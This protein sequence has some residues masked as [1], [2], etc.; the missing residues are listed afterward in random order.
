MQ[1][2]LKRMENISIQNSQQEDQY[3]EE[4][5][6]LSEKL[7]DVSN[8]KINFIMIVARGNGFQALCAL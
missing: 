5:R 4:I 1:E 2:K 7:K 8:I 6:A 3:E